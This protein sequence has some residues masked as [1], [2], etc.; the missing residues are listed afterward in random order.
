M[1]LPT[2]TPIADLFYDVVG[3]ETHRSAPGAHPGG[4]WDPWWSLSRRQRRRLI[5]GGFA[6][7]RGLMPDRLADLIES[8][9][10]GLHG[11]CPIEWYYR[12]ALRVLDERRRAA[13]RD[14]R[15]RLAERHGHRTEY[16]YRTAQARANG[17]ASLWHQRRA[18]GWQ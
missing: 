17:H 7:A 9:H 14:S 10:P 2:P 8:R 4:E 1:M 16:Q 6:T 15:Q 12:T 3:P 18:M 5:G 13:R 11:A